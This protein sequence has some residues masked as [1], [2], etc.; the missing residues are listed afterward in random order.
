M[1]SKKNVIV[2]SPG[3]IDDPFRAFTTLVREPLFEY[4]KRLREML[5]EGYEMPRVDVIDK[6][7]SFHVKVDMPDVD[8]KDIRLKVTD[9]TITVKA[10]KTEQK[11]D[12]GSGYY[13]R[14]RSS[15]GFY[16]VVEMP[17]AVKGSTAKAKY[18]NGTLTIDVQK[19]K[20]KE[21]SEVK[22]E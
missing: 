20:P 12:S 11:E 2:A 14:E 7:A 3:W 21:E 5:N 8:K 6:G 15:I 1:K 9:N 17:E 4:P 13:A 22:V 19:E 16:R 10:S 18:E